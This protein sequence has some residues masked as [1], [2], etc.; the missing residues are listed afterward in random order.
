MAG[1]DERKVFTDS[2]NHAD[3]ISLVGGQGVLVSLLLIESHQQMVDGL[4]DGQG[5]ILGEPHT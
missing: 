3:V 1:I 5:V 2:L 4:M